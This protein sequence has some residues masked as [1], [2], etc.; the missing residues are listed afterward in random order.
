[1]A[2]PFRSRPAVGVIEIQGTI[3]SGRQIAQ[4]QILL[5]RAH[6]SRRVKALLL[7]IDSPGGTVGG[8]EAL[9]MQL[10]RIAR[11]K[12]VVAYVRGIGAS[13][14]YLLSCAASSIVCLPSGLVGSIGVLMVRPAMPALMESIGIGV[15]VYKGGHLKDMTGFWREPT[16]EEDDRFKALIDETHI[17]FIRSV[18]AGRGMEEARV[19]ELATGEVFTGRAAV[20]LGLVDELGDFYRALELAAELGGVKPNPVWMR[21]KRSLVERMAGRLGRGMI[22]GAAGSLRDEMPA[23]LHYV[24]PGL[25]RSF[26]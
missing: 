13:G 23:G 14:A 18:A 11:E 15:S 19:R 6:Q 2:L 8:S 20:G 26:F 22:A 4:T 21:P 16:S 1:M 3:G 17:A 24:A 10:Q 5:Q 25:G 7:D 12:P 9:H